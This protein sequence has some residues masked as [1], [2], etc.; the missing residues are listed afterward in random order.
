MHY[1]IDRRTCR[2][3]EH[4]RMFIGTTQAV[5]HFETVHT[6]HH[7]IGHNHVG[8]HL[9]EQPKPLLSVAGHGNIEALRIERVSYD[10]RQRL[11]ILY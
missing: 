4:R 3:K 5:Y 6:R 9:C 7:Y 10:H 8:M 11:L 1:I 2:K